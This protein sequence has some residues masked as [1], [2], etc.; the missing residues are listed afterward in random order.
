MLHLSVFAGCVCGRAAAPRGPK[1]EVIIMYRSACCYDANVLLHSQWLQSGAP[2]A[3]PL[4]LKANGSVF[5]R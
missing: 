1:L 4:Q 2:L 3:T 5:E